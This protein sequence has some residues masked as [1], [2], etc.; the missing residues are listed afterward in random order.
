MSETR[1]TAP[2]SPKKKFQFGTKEKTVLSVLIGLIAIGIGVNSSITYE[3]HNNTA[4]VTTHPPPTYIGS[5]PLAVA[6]LAEARASNNDFILVVTPGKDEGLNKSITDITVAAGNKIRT[7]DGIYVG[8]FTLPKND[9]LDYPTVF[10]RLMN[11]GD[12]S[13]YQITLRSD[14]S[15]DKIYD[16]Y[17]ARKFLRNP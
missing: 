2:E 9:S 8:V 3:A 17:L 5:A 12:S 11:K 4:P 1:V 7:T 15:L 10:L 16:A 6:S 14:I 13:L